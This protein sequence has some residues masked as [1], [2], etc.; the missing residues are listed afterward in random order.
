MATFSDR[1]PV[2][3]FRPADLPALG[4]VAT[5]VPQ[6]WQNDHA[7]EV[8]PEGPTE[9]FVTHAVVEARAKGGL[10]DA[11]YGADDLRHVTHAPPWI[12]EWSG[13]FEIYF[14]E[15][16][17]RFHERLA[18]K[19]ASILVKARNWPL[20][21]GSNDA[22][23]GKTAIELRKFDWMQLREYCL[24]AENGNPLIA[25]GRVEPENTSA[26]S[27]VGLVRIA[28]SSAQLN[29]LCDDLIGSIRDSVDSRAAAQGAQE[30]PPLPPAPATQPVQNQGGL[31]RAVEFG[32]YMAQDV[33]RL[34]ECLN[35]RDELLVKIEEEGG[36]AVCAQEL[37]RA[38]EALTEAI[39][40]ARAGVYEF[41][42][43]AEIA[44]KGVGPDSSGVALEQDEQEP[45][46]IAAEA[47][48]G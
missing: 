16:M 42:K 3:N 35:A 45:G 39:S 21:D 33:G 12:R 24:T 38:Q 11:S 37:D 44:V 25:I 9:F 8:D 26:N 7:I 31:R 6:G 20:E 36:E 34:L 28:M 10:E 29:G 2:Q 18:A 22:G 41:R 43:R 48:R 30:A 47:P 40:G 13:P 5:F 27:S 14:E 23:G 1:V 19:A 17:R 15:S 46:Q 32:E 4:I